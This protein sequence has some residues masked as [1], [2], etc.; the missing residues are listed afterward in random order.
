MTIS[1]ITL[2]VNDGHFSN[3]KVM[4]VNVTIKVTFSSK[5]LK[6]IFSSKSHF[7]KN[8]FSLLEIQ[9]SIKR[10]N[11]FIVFIMEE[12][13]FMCIKSNTFFTFLNRHRIKDER[14]VPEIKK[15]LRQVY[16]FVSFWL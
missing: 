1:V 15:N 3:L 9:K 10:S 6:N 12:N 14:I 2:Q 4:K 16:L 8:F 7:F 5:L 13:V 11:V